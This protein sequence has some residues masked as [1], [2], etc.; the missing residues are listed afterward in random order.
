MPRCAK[1]EA[2]RVLPGPVL[3]QGRE[4]VRGDPMDVADAGPALGRPDPRRSP[5]HGHRLVDVEHPALEIH[6]PPAQAQRLP[7]PQ[8]GCEQNRP[9]G[10]V[11][12]LRRCR[13]E[14]LHLG[15]VPGLHLK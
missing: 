11:G 2:L 7:A 9:D 15:R 8:P 1:G 12:A 6:V 3:P 4:E 13:Q 5:R 14:A 10:A